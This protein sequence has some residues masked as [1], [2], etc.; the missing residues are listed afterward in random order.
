MDVILVFQSFKLK[1]MLST[2]DSLSLKSFV[3]YKFICTGCNA[4]YVGLTT[5]HLSTRVHEHFNDKQSHIHKH[6]ECNTACLQACDVSCFTVIDSA[7]TE[8]EL[9]IKEAIHIQ[10]LRP[11]INKQIKSFKLSLNL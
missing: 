8:Y 6:L 2:K 9:K 4:Y 1:N 3:V 10:W 5:R 11:T 7:N